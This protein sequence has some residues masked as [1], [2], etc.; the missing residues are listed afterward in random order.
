MTVGTNHRVWIENTV[1]FKNHRSQPLKVDLVDDAVAWGHNPKV[2]ECLFTPLKESKSLL[3]STELELFVLFLCVG[4]SGKINLNRV[5]DDQINLTEWV[6]ET[7]VATELLHS[8]SHRSEVYNCWYSSEVLKQD[9][10]GFKGYF[11]IL[12]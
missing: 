11:D 6:D 10:R 2:V 12:F 8:G 4:I 5:I 3:I 7:W 1:S 9:S